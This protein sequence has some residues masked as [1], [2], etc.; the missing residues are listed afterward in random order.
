VSLI[1]EALK[2]VE[3]ERA[4]PE[5]RGFLVLGPAAWAPARSRLGMVAGMAVAAIVAGAAVYLATRPATPTAPVSARTDEP[6]VAPL[7]P[8]V[9]PVTIVPVPAVTTAVPAAPPTGGTIGLPPLLDAP[10][11]LLVSTPGVA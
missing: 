9:P 2:K 6:A 3:R 8:P 11:S 1:L 4:T 10:K 5:Q 7:A